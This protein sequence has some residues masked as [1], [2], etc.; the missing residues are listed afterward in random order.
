[1]DAERFD[2]LTRAMAAKSPRRT[3]LRG[4]LGLAA[5]VL[6]LS[7]LRPAS[8]VEPAGRRHTAVRRYPSAGK[9]EAVAASLKGLLPEMEKSAGFVDWSV[10]DA[11]AGVIV[12]VSV[13]SSKKDAEGAAKLEVDWI[14][15]HAA[16]QLPKPP[17]I[18]EGSVLLHAGRGVGCPCTTGVRN[19]CGSDR[20]VCCA[21]GSLAGRPGTCV[22]AA[23]GC[24]VMPAPTQPTVVP[25][26]CV[27][28]AQSCPDGCAKGT[29]CAGCC[30]GSCRSDGICGGQSACTV[31][32]GGACSANEDCCVGTCG[33]VCHCGQPDRPDVG[34]PCATGDA[35]ACGG[36]PA[37]C[38]PI[39]PGGPG[40]AGTCISPMADCDA[41]LGCR[42]D[43]F[44]CP[45]ACPAGTACPACCSGA[46]L[47]DGVCG[48]SAGVC[49]AAGAACPA[50]PD[51]CAGLTCFEALCDDPKGACAAAGAACTAPGDCC[52]GTCSPGG[53]CYCLD[54]D[55]PQIGCPCTVG[56]AA[57]CSG[58]PDLCCAGTCIS[59]MATC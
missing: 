10:V 33:G 23:K 18:V 12:T 42:Q 4:G 35:G 2:L 31:E 21:E 7:A 37:R 8:A 57:A 1:M 20:L 25:V 14:A 30:K 3:A 11:G 17:V 50:N 47:A 36:T 24:E 15:E 53:V 5:A 22:D 28:D 54:P 41:K 6:G 44:V 19:P 51:C 32:V 9:P 34:C 48:A 46:C 45:I 56:D 40:G 55:R 52:S 58:R 27:A 16:K 39:G 13:F 43:A 38:C 59:P 29:A 26:Q 49:G